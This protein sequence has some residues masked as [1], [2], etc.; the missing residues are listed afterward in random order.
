[1]ARRPK[2]ESVEVVRGKTVLVTGGAGFIGSH[3]A[4]RLVTLGAHVIIFDK[5][6]HPQSFFA[7]SNLSKQ[8]VFEKVDISDKKAVDA[9]YKKYTP[10][11]IFHLA[12]ETIVTESFYSPWQT[13]NSNIMGTVNILEAVRKFKKT[14]GLIFASSDKAYGKT[15]K[16][17][18]EQS[19]LKGDHPYDVSKSSADL[20]THTYFTTYGLSVVIARFGNVFGEGDLHMDRIIPGICEAIIK[21]KTLKIRSDGTFVRDYVYVQDVVDGYLFLLRNLKKING[22]AFNLSSSETY[23]VLELLRKA[24]KILHQRIPFKILNTQKNEIP[25][26]RLNNRK[27]KKLGWKPRYSLETTLAEILEWYRKIL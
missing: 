7:V 6:V 3:L 18:T 14:K 22:E 4:K 25:F 23:S 5:T 11:Y 1:M 17:Y 21:R 12:A 20:I 16:S 27:V 19:P 10:Y 15:K 9:L 2:V 8:V 24:E 26:Q 13:F